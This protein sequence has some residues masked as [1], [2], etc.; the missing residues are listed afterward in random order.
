MFFFSLIVFFLSFL[1]LLSIP[2]ADEGNN[3]YS[4]LLKIK[5]KTKTPTTTNAAR[6]EASS[7]SS[8]RRR[9]ASPAP[10]RP[11]RAPP[12][13]SSSRAP[14]PWGATR[15]STSTRPRRTRR[16]CGRSPSGSTAA[17]LGSVSFLVFFFDFFFVS[18]EK[19]ETESDDKLRAHFFLL[20]TQKPF[21]T[22]QVLSSPRA[23]P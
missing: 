8:P 2:A 7:S 4:H 6:S 17:W 20:S 22:P 3:N 19:R 16:G 11:P 13:R 5:Q 12:Q 9:P 14:R 23:S 10:P 18:R 1:P 15:P 21:F